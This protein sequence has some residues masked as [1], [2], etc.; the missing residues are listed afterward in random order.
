[1]PDAGDGQGNCNAVRVN[2]ATELTNW[3][4]DDPTDT[5]TPNVLII[6]DL[7][8]YAVRTRSLL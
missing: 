7:N 6:G 3:L 8:C 4:A 5:G 2:A 1:M